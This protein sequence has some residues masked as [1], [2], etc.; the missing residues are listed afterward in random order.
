MDAQVAPE[1]VL[2]SP[3]PDY[4]C[5]PQFA[6]VHLWVEIHRR[7]CGFLGPCYIPR[8]PYGGFRQLLS[9][10]SV[11]FQCATT[12]DAPSEVPGVWQRSRLLIGVATYA[13]GVDLDG[14]KCLPARGE[15]Y[16]FQF[17]I[18]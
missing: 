5:S 9:P 11:L 18:R 14:R 2:S 13:T 10:G 6:L 12:H 4:V 15:D 1:G 3:K 17:L 16:S 7:G 8:S